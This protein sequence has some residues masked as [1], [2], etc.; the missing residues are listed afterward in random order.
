MVSVWILMCIFISSWAEK[1]QNDLCSCWR[2]PLG[3][4]AIF[5]YCYCFVAY[6]RK[7]S[8][9]K[10]VNYLASFLRMKEWVCV[11]KTKKKWS[12]IKSRVQSWF[13][14]F[15]CMDFFGLFSEQKIKVGSPK[16]AKKVT[17]HGFSLNFEQH[18]Y[19]SVRR[20]VAKQFT[21]HHN[22]KN[23]FRKKSFVPHFC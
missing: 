16:V 2:Q 18:F 7:P 11:A 23:S 3:G 10:R 12:E 20:K 1:W 17:K 15:R 14:S 9:C 22:H 21:I 5:F 8:C 4:F 13:G 19:F 6:S